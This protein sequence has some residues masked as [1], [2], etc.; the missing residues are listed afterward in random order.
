MNNIGTDIAFKLWGIKKMTQGL[1]G[2]AIKW[3][4]G[5]YFLRRGA[6]LLFFL[7]A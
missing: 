7:T 2:G 5:E 1:K 6:Q 4:P 3:N